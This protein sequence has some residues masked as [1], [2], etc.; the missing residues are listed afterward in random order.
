MI[1]IYTVSETL[2]EKSL[3]VLPMK[4][5]IRANDLFKPF[6]V[7]IKEKNLPMDK[8]IS[9]CTN[10]EKQR[11]GSTFREYDKRPILSFHCILHQEALCAQIRAINDH[12]FK[13]LLDE[14]G[15]NY[16]A[17]V[18]QCALVVKRES[19]QSVGVAKVGP[20]LNSNK[21]GLLSII[22]VNKKGLMYVDSSHVLTSWDGIIK[23]MELN[24][25][26]NYLS[27]RYSSFG[28]QKVDMN[29][30]LKLRLKRL[31]NAMVSNKQCLHILKS[32]VITMNH[33][34]VTKFKIIK[35]DSKDR[36]LVV[37]NLLSTASFAYNNRMRS[38]VNSDNTYIRSL[39]CE[40][41]GLFADISIK[42]NITLVHENT[43]FQELVRANLINSVDTKGIKNALQGLKR[44]VQ[45]MAGNVAT[46]SKFNRYK[47]VPKNSKY[48]NCGKRVK[49]LEHSPRTRGFRIER[50]DKL[51]EYLDLKLRRPG[52]QVFKTQI[53]KI[54]Q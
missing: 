13:S 46:K 26:Y 8:L 25:L 5:K 45:I 15:Y 31:D 38:L 14:V 9:L 2:H 52:V 37:M 41:P 30:D 44:D 19:A 1:A 40:L 7:I 6:T 29:N 54:G 42:Y 50:H 10:G 35:G 16:P 48:I 23:N 24:D 53:Y 36:G 22:E 21:S 20:S 12:Q 34:A 18:N 17:I 51:V 33:Y 27:I 49:H 11:I 39:Y 47:V 4:V 3:T 32:N 43:K 28:H